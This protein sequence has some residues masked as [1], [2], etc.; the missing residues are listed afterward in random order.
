MNKKYKCIASLLIICSLFLF[1]L[2]VFSQNAPGTSG[3]P[4]VTKSYLD[5]A[6]K[7]RKIE[8]KSG[9]QIKAETGA[10]IIVV[11]GQLKVELNKGCFVVDLTNGRK[12]TSNS[13]LQSFHLIMVIDGANC[14]FKASKDASLMA[15]GIN[16]DEVE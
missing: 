3:D 8:V 16:D 13:T 15:L 1:P 14:A 5:F 11:S 9:T 10:M 4:L 7:F 2:N 12:I 6:A